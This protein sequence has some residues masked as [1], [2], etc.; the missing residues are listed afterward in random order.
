MTS[1]VY[2]TNVK[3]NLYI[4]SIC[5]AAIEFF[6]FLSRYKL[7]SIVRF[8]SNNRDKVIIICQDFT[9]SSWPFSIFSILS[10][11]LWDMPL[12]NSNL[13]KSTGLWKWY[14]KAALQQFCFQG[15]T[16]ANM[17]TGTLWHRPL[18]VGTLL[19]RLLLYII[20]NS[21]SP[22]WWKTRQNSPISH[23]TLR[24]PTTN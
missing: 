23:Q 15:R 24:I 22:R 6:F 2:L 11:I 12:I 18:S 21:S 3:K 9:K 4:F 16:S 8:I 14:E 1:F 20:L 5:K 7:I 10:K 13:M 19:H 17:M